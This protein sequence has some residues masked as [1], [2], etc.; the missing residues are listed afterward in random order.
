MKVPIRSKLTFCVSCSKSFKVHFKCKKYFIED[1]WIQKKWIRRSLAYSNESS[2]PGFRKT[3]HQGEKREWKMEWWMLQ[4]IHVTDNVCW[5]YMYIWSPLCSFLHFNSGSFT[6][7]VQFTTSCHEFHLHNSKNT[8]FM[9][10]AAFLYHP[11]M[12]FFLLDHNSRSISVSPDYFCS[13]QAL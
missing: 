7:G 5:L 11:K 2:R 4:L 12:G 10:S 8:L 13:N 9:W 6:R 3:Y 1:S